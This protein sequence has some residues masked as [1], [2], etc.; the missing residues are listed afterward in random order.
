MTKEKFLGIELGSTRIKGVL[1][2]SNAQVISHSTFQWENQFENKL[3][4]YS[5]D[6]VKMGVQSCFSE[7]SND[8]KLQFNEELEF[9][10][11]M[12]FSAMMHGYLAFDKNGNLLTPFR[13][14]RNTNTMVAAE[15]LTKKLNFNIPLRW[16]IA[17]LYQAIL[18]DEEHV[19]DIDFLTT[20]SGYVHWKLTGKKVLGIGDASGMFPI[21]HTTNNYNQRMI[22]IFDHLI[23]DKNFSWKLIEILPKV[24]LAGENAGKI[25][26]DGVKYLDQKGILKQGIIL[27]PPEG[28]A[29]T[30]MVATNTVASKTGNIS[31][32][33]SIFAMIVLD[34]PLSKIYR[35][36]D[37]VA[38][39]NGKPVA[40]VHCNNCTSDINAWS[41][42]LYEFSQRLGVDCSI[43]KVYEILYSAAIEGN[44]GNLISYNYVSGE[45]ITEV[46]NGCPLF[47]R[48]PNAD[49]SFVNFARSH[50]LSSIATLKIGMDILLTTESITIDKIFGHGGFFTVKNI[51]QQ[52][53]ADLLK[54]PI[55]VM[56]TESEGGVWGMALLS[57][58][59]HL[60][61]EQDL[62]LFLEK[63]IFSHKKINTIVPDD[64]SSDDIELFMSNY[65][66]AL[67]LEKLA[68][69]IFIN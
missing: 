2:D 24:L 20:L 46:E 4:T 17:H 36:I 59:T 39:P 50:I 14:W 44:C 31:A 43:T 7:I 18:D 49:F 61:K 32:G 65:K 22:E 35:D 10:N 13:T 19:K 12:G 15:I 23:K 5:L 16:S 58:Y 66:T 1:I 3:W 57:A 28:D 30:G 41:N 64:K 69:K 67:D 68:S 42:I 38:T 8:Y 40:M 54:I 27:A 53:M 9:I 29:G 47:I 62:D 6:A 21:D 26:E 52:I 37:I 56:Q 60:N 63:V 51:G 45:P 55:S 33:T 34:K 11:T 25:T 48:L